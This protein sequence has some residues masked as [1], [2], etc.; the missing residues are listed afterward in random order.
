L[1][2]R[3]GRQLRRHALAAKPRGESASLAGLFYAGSCTRSSV[4][5]GVGDHA[6]AEP[7]AGTR[8][9]SPRRNTWRY[10]PAG[11]CSSAE[12]ATTIQIDN[13]PGETGSAASR[14]KRPISK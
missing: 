8:T 9:V 4:A 14:A 10:G 2:R 7:D 3:A 11:A 1:G 5:L 13:R 6:N 12:P